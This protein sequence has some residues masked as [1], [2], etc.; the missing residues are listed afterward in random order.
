M[1]TEPTTP[2][3]PGSFVT[4]EQI[5][6][7]LWAPRATQVLLTAVELDLFSHLAAGART[8]EQTAAAAGT[9]PRGTRHVL[10]ALTALGYLE[11]R[12]GG[13][14]LTLASRRYLV[15]DS[16]GY[17]GDMCHETRALWQQWPHL[18][19]VVR[20]GEPTARWEEEATGR[21]QFPALVSAWFP[22][23]FAAARAAV[24]ALPEDTRA[25]IHRILDVAAGSGAW[26]IAFALDLPQARVTTIDHP[27]VTDVTRSFTERYGVAERYRHIGGNI[28]TTEFGTGYDLVTLGYIVHTE[29]PHWGPE[30]IRKA[31]AA[32]RPGG[33]LLIADMI[34]DNS[35]TG[36]HIPLTFAATDLLLFTQD[37][38]T[39]TQREYEAWLTEAGFH[40]VT[41]HDILAPSPLITATR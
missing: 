2:S 16:P 19:E 17:L 5:I 18:T 38:D 37:G 4:P 23:S 9:A 30:L 27:E 20:T 29:G 8:A 11:K 34:P 32:L 12:D 41:T 10:D 33:T 39:Y 6:D 25:G 1:P 36:P 3:E 13:Y 7:D 26:S 35:R 31:Y 21:E 14:E 22:L 40:T 15:R 28:R 24:A